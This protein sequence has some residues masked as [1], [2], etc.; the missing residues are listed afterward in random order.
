MSSKVGRTKSEINRIFGSH[1]N[2]KSEKKKRGNKKSESGYGSLNLQMS[3]GLTGKVGPPDTHVAITVR[4]SG[5]L[6]CV[7]ILRLHG[8]PPLLC[9]LVRCKKSILHGSPPV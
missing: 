7:H 9:T 6:I 2:F 4:F 1:I 5:F 3:V 8:P